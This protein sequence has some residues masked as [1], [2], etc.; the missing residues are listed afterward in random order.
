MRII[1]AYGLP[2]SGKST[3]L[4]NLY[5]SS[6]LVKQYINYDV[7]RSNKIF[8]RICENVISC[9][10]QGIEEVYVD[11]LFKKKDISNLIEYLGNYVELILHLEYIINRFEPNIEQCINNDN[12]RN[13]DVKATYTIK[14]MKIKKLKSSDVNTKK[15]NKITI[16]EHEVYREA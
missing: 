8:L 6:K 4:T 2:G 16:I 1:L 9:S 5:N 15:I 10:E 13:R 11:Y 14:D 3:L 7:K 12:L